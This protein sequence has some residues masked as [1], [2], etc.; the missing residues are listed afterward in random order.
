MRFIVAQRWFAEFHLHNKQPDP[1]A[2]V[3]SS[4]IMSFMIRILHD[5]VCYPYRAIL[6][7]GTKNFLTK[8]GASG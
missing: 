8:L 5:V 6:T 1:E 3:H 2:S 4:Y 7:T